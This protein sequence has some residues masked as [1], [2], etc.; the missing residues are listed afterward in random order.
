MDKHRC[1]LQ[2]FSVVISVVLP[3]ELHGLQS[4]AKLKAL[5]RCNISPEEVNFATPHILHLWV[6]KLPVIA[7][8]LLGCELRGASPHKKIHLVANNFDHL[9]TVDQGVQV[10]IR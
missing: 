1:H 8:D 4:A 3:T 5:L 10:L 9:C 2:A 7:W 6:A